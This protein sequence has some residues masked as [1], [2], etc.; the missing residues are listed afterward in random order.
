MKDYSY[1]GKD[2][3]EH[4]G[5][6]KNWKKYFSQ[7]IKP[8]IKGDVLEIGCA[9]GAS[10]KYLWKDSV[11]SWTCMDPDASLVRKLTKKYEDSFSK[12]IKSKIGMIIDLTENDT[13]DTILYLDVLE[14]IQQDRQE[15]SNALKHLNHSGKL[16]ILSPAHQIL[17]TPFDQHVGHYRRYNKKELVNLIDGE[18]RLLKA[19]YM[20]SVGMIASVGNRFILN[21]SIP[22]I[23][24]IRIWDNF[25]IPL[26]RILD[27]IVNFR[28]GKSLLV[29][30]EKI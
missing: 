21:A 16:I 6:A 9:D 2:L 23:K 24:Q 30:W 14:H 27:P 10:T 7:K 1:E 15:L 12:K 18:V 25:M 8:F 4:F 28:L 11:S 20:D 5:Y 22:S 17:Y 19:I 26:S 3:V 13:Y 29:V